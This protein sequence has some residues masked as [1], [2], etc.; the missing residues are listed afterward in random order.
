MPPIHSSSANNYNDHNN[1]SSDD[2]L[3]HDDEYDQHD[4]YYID[5]LDDEYDDHGSPAGA[6][7]GSLGQD[8]TEDELPD[9]GVGSL[10][11]DFRQ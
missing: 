11:V 8:A 4:I 10:H 1:E 9:P 6:C 3:N 2:N 5:N 7:A